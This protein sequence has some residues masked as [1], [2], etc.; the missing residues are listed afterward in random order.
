MG[1]LILWAKLAKDMGH[2]YY[3]K[4]I[5]RNV[6]LY[7]FIIVILGIIS[8]IVGLIIRDPSMINEQ[9]NPFA[10]LF[11]TLLEWHFPPIL[12]IFRTIKVIKCYFSGYNKSMIIENTFLKIC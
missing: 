1:D 7:I 5:R 6:F 3:G 11:K 4:F 12:K 9:A 10:T 2:S 8:C